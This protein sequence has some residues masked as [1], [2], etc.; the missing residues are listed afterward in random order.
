M[1]RSISFISQATSILYYFRDIKPGNIL[2]NV[3]QDGDYDLMTI[4]VRLLN[5]KLCD[6]GLSRL[7]EGADSSRAMSTV[8]T[9]AYAAPE[10]RINLANKVTISDYTKSC[11]IFSSGV[12]I[13]EVVFGEL[14]D[15][16]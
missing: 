5:I 15:G 13:H 4:S 16:R 6:F 9:Q 8:G 12:V 14:L 1:L 10:I 3:A 7:V 11:D 2:I